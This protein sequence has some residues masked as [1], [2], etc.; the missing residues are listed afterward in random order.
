MYGLRHTPGRKAEG[1]GTEC[2]HAG[3]SSG[4]M[5]INL[6]YFMGARQICLLGY[7]MQYTDGKAHFFGD[8]KQTSNPSSCMMRRWVPK[9][10]PLWR[11]LK[12][13]GIELV[14]CTRETAL[15]I[16]RARLEDVL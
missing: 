1:L 13:L 10:E 2:L 9:F 11:D 14:N 12:A 15:T 4:Y 5:A 6:A 3:G 7:D 16:P 8:H